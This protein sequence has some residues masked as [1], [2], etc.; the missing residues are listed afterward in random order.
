MPLMVQGKPAFQ[1]SLKIEAKS[2]EKNPIT[3]GFIITKHT[4]K[5]FSIGTMTL[6]MIPRGI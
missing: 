5:T 4:Q 2:E 3:D 1:W 6:K